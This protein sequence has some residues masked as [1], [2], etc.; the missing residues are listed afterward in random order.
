MWVGMSWVCEGLSW[1]EVVE[2]MK[3]LRGKAAGPDETMNKM[4]MYRG[5]R[6]VEVMLLMI[7]VVKNSECS[8]LDWKD[9]LLVPLHKYGGCG[10]SW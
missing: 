9:G 2:V 7:S 1:D 6:L 10:R 3:C 5:G 4:L 8:P